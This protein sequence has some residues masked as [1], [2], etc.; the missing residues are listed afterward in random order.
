[1][2]WYM[3]DDTLNNGIY[4]DI[5]IEEE[6]TDETSWSIVNVIDISQNN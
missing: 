4:D 2:G 1:M 3:N 6:S 5:I